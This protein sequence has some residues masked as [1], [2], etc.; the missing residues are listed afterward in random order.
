[1]VRSRIVSGCYLFM[2]RLTCYLCPRMTPVSCDD[3]SSG[4]VTAL[5]ADD[6]KSRHAHTHTA[7]QHQQHRHNAER[8]MGEISCEGG[9]VRMNSQT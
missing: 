1:M 5:S 6:E 2:S 4:A 7:A 8:E 3:A 9:T